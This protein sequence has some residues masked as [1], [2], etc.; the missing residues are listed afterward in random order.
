MTSVSRRIFDNSFYKLI[1]RIDLL[2]QKMVS[3]VAV[4]ENPMKTAP[5]VGRENEMTRIIG[6]IRYEITI[7]VGC[8]S[9]F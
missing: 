5:F 2:F 1:L 9:F 8:K 3:S 6:I 4:Q 7:Y